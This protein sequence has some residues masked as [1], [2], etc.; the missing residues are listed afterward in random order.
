MPKITVGEVSRIETHDSQGRVNG[1]LLPIWNIHEW[2]MVQQVDQVYL[3]TINPGL[4]KGPHLHMKRRGFFKVIRGVIRLVVR[5]EFGVYMTTE[6]GVDDSAIT[7]PPGLPAALYN[8]GPTEAYVLNMPSPAW[9]PDD[10]DEW[11]VEGWD[12]KP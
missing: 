12:Y 3:T 1:W 5:N 8:F 2:S 4:V 6:M 10:Q 7:V 11:P 9:R